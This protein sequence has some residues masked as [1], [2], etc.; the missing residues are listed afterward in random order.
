MDLT[1]DII[2]KIL[3]WRYRYRL[4][5]YYCADEVNY[6]DFIFITNYGYV[7][8]IEIKTSLA[9]LRADFK[10]QKHNNIKNDY[11][12]HVNYFYF[13]VPDYLLEKATPIIEGMN[14]KYGIIK[15]YSN[16][17]YDIKTIKKAKLLQ[18]CFKDSNLFNNIKENIIARLTSK[19]AT[20][21]LNDLRKVFK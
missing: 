4:C 11:K 16:A 17:L 20:E 19:I 18:P 9:D 13:A 7:G 5:Y 21:S 6:K 14:T 8:E 3:Y 1:A 12:I 15:I 2:K 10:K